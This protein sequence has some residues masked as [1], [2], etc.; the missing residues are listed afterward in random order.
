MAEQAEETVGIEVP[1]ETGPGEQAEERTPEQL[2]EAAYEEQARATG[3][4]PKDKYTGPAGTWVNA[5]D[6]LIREPLFNKIKEQ[7]SRIKGMTKTM[8][9]MNNQFQKQVEAQVRRR[10]KELEA[11]KD[12]AIELGD[13]QKVR[14]I[15][16]EIDAQR[17]SSETVKPS[18]PNDV[19]EWIEENPWFVS[20]KEMN[21]FAIAHNKAYVE[22]NPGAD[23]VMSLKATKAAVMKAYPD[24]FAP[25]GEVEKEKES[26]RTPNP[27]EGGAEPKGDGKKKYTKER[28]T[29]EQKRVYD[30]MVTKF[31]TLTHDE[32]FKG[33][34]EIGELQ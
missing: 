24:R 25:E 14:E 34:E 7:N 6:F 8:E 12:S 15:D 32:F 4:L 21:S 20:D 23:P 29:S 26:A 17:K 10:L 13:V 31:G 11:E 2:E 5:R 1:G 3:W 9:A 19:Q 27:V 22:N 30:Q 16:A 28:L 18:V 33:L